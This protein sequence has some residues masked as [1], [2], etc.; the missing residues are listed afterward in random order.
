[1]KI[2]SHRSGL[3]GFISA[4]AG[5]VLAV[6]IGGATML[7]YEWHNAHPGKSGHHASSGGGKSHHKKKESKTAGN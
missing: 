5:I 6:L 3:R 4:K 2:H 7:A 1:M